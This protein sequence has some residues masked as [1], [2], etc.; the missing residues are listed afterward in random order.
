M[1]QGRQTIQIAFYSTFESI[2]EYRDAFKSR[3]IDFLSVIGSTCPLCGKRDCYRE[4]T[5]Y[6]RYAIDLFPQLEKAL[7]PVA[8]FLCCNLRRTFSLLPI[9]LIPYV[10]Y[11]VGA[12]VGTLLAGLGC[13]HL[14]GQGFWGAAVAVDPD[15]SV[16]PW[17]VFA[18]LKMVLCGF[19]RGH[20]TLSRWY[21]MS[22]LTSSGNPGLW[23]SLGDYFQ[24]LGWR[25]DSSWLR[26]GDV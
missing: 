21:D 20:R 16:T 15:S 7:V 1:R 17:L 24:A 18:W 23:Q 12:V 25:S 14:G 9:H 10:M 5:P 3:K 26:L 2:W 19:Q 6:W 4:I 22:F 13:R 8:R 11:T